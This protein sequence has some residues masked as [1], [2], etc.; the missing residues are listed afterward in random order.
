ML[1][2]EK[3]YEDMID[4]TITAADVDK[5]GKINLGDASKMLKSVA[6]RDD[7]SLGNVRR[8]FENT[9]LTA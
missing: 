4:G 8:V 1:D 3:G 2:F 6:K 7:I 5:N 9:K